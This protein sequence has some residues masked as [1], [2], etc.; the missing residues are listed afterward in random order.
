MVKLG[1]TDRRYFLCVVPGDCRLDMEAVKQLAN[2]THVLLAPGDVAA[3]L[4][5]CVSGA[6][7]PV[8]FHPD[9]ELVVDPR[10]LDNDAIVFNAGCLEQSMFVDREAYVRAASPAIASIGLPSA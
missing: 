2:G 10:L 4:T 9:L 1:K 7:P 3:K 5:S 6:I 8:S